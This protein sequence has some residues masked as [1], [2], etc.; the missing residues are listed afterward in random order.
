MLCDLPQDQIEE[1][2][3]VRVLHLGVSSKNERVK[4][5]N[6]PEVASLAKYGNFPLSGRSQVFWFCLVS[7]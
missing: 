2:F 6:R 7:Y 5:T 4:A 1:V 3:I